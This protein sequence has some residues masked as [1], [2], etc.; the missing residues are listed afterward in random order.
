M[1]CQEASKY[2]T[3]NNITSLTILMIGRFPKDASEFR[4]YASLLTPPPTAE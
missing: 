4:Y 2:G 3:K 1:L